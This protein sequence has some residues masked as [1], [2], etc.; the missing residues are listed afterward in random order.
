MAPVPIPLDLMGEERISGGPHSVVEGE[1]VVD[2]LA[3]H[4]AVDLIVDYALAK[5]TPRGLL[6]HRLVQV[7]VR[8]RVERRDAP[9]QSGSLTIDSP[10][11]RAIA[12]LRRGA[13]AIRIES[14]EGWDEW[15]VSSLTF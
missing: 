11:A 7:A 9:S 4:D 6:F 13:P 5:N 8:N 10:L 12:M 14:P 1:S 2:P 3:L 15:D